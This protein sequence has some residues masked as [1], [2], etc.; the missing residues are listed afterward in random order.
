MKK[1]R[2]IV[3]GALSALALT[4]CS[5]F[6]D[7]DVDMTINNHF[8]EVV[9]ENAPE[10]KNFN[11]VD[12]RDTKIDDT[13][14]YLFK[15]VVYSNTEDGKIKN[16]YT[17]ES[18]KCFYDVNGG[19]DYEVNS[20]NNN[21]DMYVPESAYQKKA[22]AQTVVLF[23]HGGAWISGAK[24][25]VNSYVKEFAK[26]GYIAATIEYSL[27]SSAALTSDD[28]D[29]ETLAKNRSLSL[30]RDLDEID[31]CIYTMKQTLTK[32][33][34]TGDLSLVIGGVSSGAHLTML[35][36]YSRGSSSAFGA[37]KFVVNAVGPTDIKED[38]WKA[39]V[40]DGGDVLDSI[41]KDHIAAQEAASNLKDLHISG[42][43]SWNWNEYQTMRIANGMAG[44]HF[45]PQAVSNTSASKVTVDN[46]TGDV[47]KNIVSNANSAE[48]L[49]SVTNYITSEHNIPMICA[50]GGKDVIVG[51]KQYAKLQTALDLAGI[52]YEPFYFKDKGHVNIDEKDEEGNRPIYDAFINKIVNWLGTK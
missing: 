32:V 20:S 19:E 26:R 41:D 45:S 8:N 39:F 15:N 36:S 49:L 12:Y 16:T 44:F 3:I 43:D 7:K 18:G 1:T 24:T 4:S 34:F 51:I 30:F 9:K 17:L 35:Y 46:K 37:P 47:Y 27:L 23:I 22:E 25:H 10:T 42:T 40:N 28:M 21:F 50:Y 29:A 33:G 14:A 31:A 38:V 6:N 52:E 13:N 48:N 5:L 2:F 11:G